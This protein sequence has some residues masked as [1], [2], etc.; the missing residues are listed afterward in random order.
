M[1]LAP[2]T[3]A[4]FQL[5][6]ALVRA[7]H[8]PSCARENTRGGLRH[9]ARRKEAKDIGVNLSVAY[10]GELLHERPVDLPKYPRQLDH[11]KF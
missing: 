8:S 10:L 2:R 3:R 4:S 6:G 9:L 5:T 11:L 7:P 1:L